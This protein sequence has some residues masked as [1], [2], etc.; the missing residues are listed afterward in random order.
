M[1]PILT[2]SSL[3]IS[4]FREEGEAM[5]KTAIRVL[6]FFIILGMILG[7]LNRLFAFKYDDG[8][9]QMSTFYDLDDTVDVLI[10]GSSHAFVNFNNG[11]LWDKYGMASYNLGGSVQPMWNSYYFLKEALKTSKP[12]LVVLE[13]YGTTFNFEYSDDSRIIKNTYGMKWSSNKI[14]A[15]KASAEKERT[16]EFLMDYSQYHTRYSTLNQNDFI[17]TVDML[18]TAERWYYSNWK[19]QFLFYEYRPIEIMDVSEITEEADLQ[20][21]QRNIIEKH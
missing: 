19:G 8:I 9:S 11:T 7:V 2:Q 4:N 17:D 5:I 18:S 21:K 14:D 1:D 10:I 20:E 12:E 13:G 6:S 16:L 3:S 15:I